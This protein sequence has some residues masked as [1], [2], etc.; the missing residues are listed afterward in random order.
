MAKR[1]TSLASQFAQGLLEFLNNMETKTFNLLDIRNSKEPAKEMA[2]HILNLREQGLASRVTDDMM[3]MADPETLAKFTPLDMS[4]EARMQRARDMGF[5]TDT[6]LYHGAHD[7]MPETD[8]DQYGNKIEIPPYRKSDIKAFDDRPEQTS[9]YGSDSTVF[10]TDNSGVAN[11]YAK[12]GNRTPNNQIY[13]LLVKKDV[14]DPM[15]DVG[16]TPYFGIPYTAQGKTGENIKEIFGPNVM[17]ND[18]NLEDNSGAIDTTTDL[19][20]KQM[21]KKDLETTTL[22][23]IS[24]RGPQTPTGT[25]LDKDV[26]ERMTADEIAKLKEYNKTIQKQSIQPATD[27]MV[28]KGNRIRSPF[29]RFDPEFAHLKNISASVVPVSVGMAQL[30]Q[31]PDVTKEEIEEY[32][33]GAGL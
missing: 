24:D 7:A 20:A 15:I 1:R 25:P 21:P 2:G 28:Q 32:L 10:L 8:F 22:F 29:A 30:L 12:V 17:R 13:P 31:K 23:N 6:M 5:D 3:A 9:I 33:S 11:S 14:N 18:Y 19:I 16:G 4:T 27:V 26:L